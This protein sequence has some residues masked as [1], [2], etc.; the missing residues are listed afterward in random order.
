MHTSSPIIKEFDYCPHPL[1]T[2]ALFLLASAGAAMFGYMSMHVQG[3]ANIRGI[4]FTEEQQRWFFRIL[5]LLSPIGLVPLGISVF[6]A[7][8]RKRR[9][10]L[11]RDSL[12][13]PKPTL[14]SLSSEEIEIRFANIKSVAV[15]DFVGSAK[16]LRIEYTDGVVDIFSNM[17]RGKMMFEEV[18]NAVTAATEEHEER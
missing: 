7:V 16:L 18:T 4:Q 1:P 17:F 10:S 11:S 9:I 6:L 13:L 5:L 15:R 3:G 8:F 2:V 14:L 12:V